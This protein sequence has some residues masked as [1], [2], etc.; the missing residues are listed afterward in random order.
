MNWNT[1]SER[2]FVHARPIQIFLLQVL[3]SVTFAVVALYPNFSAKWGIINDH[4]I[5]SFLG[6]DF[7]MGLGEIPSMFIKTAGAKPGV[8]LRYQP[9]YWI[10]RLF[11]VALWQDNLFLWYSFRVF[12]FG[13]I[14]FVFWRF[15]GQFFGFTM[16]GLICGVFLA[17][18]FWSDFLTRL[19]IAEAYC[20]T[21]LGVYLLAFSKIWMNPNLQRRRTWWTLLTLSAIVTIG[22]KENFLFLLPANA[23][24]LNRCR[25]EE[26]LDLFVI[27]CNLF[28]FSLGIFITVALL[29]ALGRQGID[30]YANPVDPI[31]RFHTL[32][33]VLVS[34]QGQV[35]SQ[36]P[37]FIS[38]CMVLIIYVFH[39]WAPSRFRE[40]VFK[41][42]KRLI[43]LESVLSLIWYS[44]LIF[45]NG[46]WPVGTRYDFPGVLTRD[47]AFILLFYFPIRMIRLSERP[48]QFLAMG[49]FALAIGFV[50]FLSISGVKEYIQ[51]YGD[52]YKNSVTTQKFTTSLKRIVSETRDHRGVPIILVSHS[53]WDYE[54]VI[55]LRVFLSVF[56]LNN[57]LFLKIEWPQSTAKN[58]T[59]RVL[60]AGLRKLS[61]TGDLAEERITASGEKLI[62][63]LPLTSLKNPESCYVISISGDSRSTCSN[64]GRIWN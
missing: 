12:L 53:V 30:F 36:I 31:T 13:V 23:L 6:S 50:T 4:R 5:M 45:Y 7:R 2:N 39:R 9:I 25:K 62:P 10:V 17:H 64:L 33:N 43:A 21:A 15:L 57:P 32:L 27:V 20:A 38:L 61:E 8:S 18:N 60:A 37:F 29:V 55:S 24:L 46:N 22:S 16:G 26:G 44:Q 54:P 3:L 59:E 41:E 51:L 49:N 48:P 14:I 58:A 40:S 47:V 63:F 34:S 56:G 19:G 1:Q 52:S 11:E 35:L 28:L 42:A